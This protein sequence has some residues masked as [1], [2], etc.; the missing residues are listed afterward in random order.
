MLNTINSIYTICC[1]QYISEAWNTLKIDAT[2]FI[3]CILKILRKINYLYVRTPIISEQMKNESTVAASCLTRL[4][5]NSLGYNN[6]SKSKENHQSLHQHFGLLILHTENTATAGNPNLHTCYWKY[7]VV[8]NR[9]VDVSCVMVGEAFFC[10]DNTQN[11]LLVQDISALV[12]ILMGHNTTYSIIY[13]YLSSQP[14]REAQ[15]TNG[16]SRK[17]IMYQKLE[18]FNSNFSLI[19]L[20][21]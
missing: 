4:A 18:D 14:K 11:P 15:H 7:C 2:E 10:L 3:F 6:I 13:M 20:C 16:F 17:Q 19:L 1:S 21:R 5:N 9:T 8:L 12:S